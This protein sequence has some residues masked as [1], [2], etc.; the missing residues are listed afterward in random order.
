MKLGAKGNNAGGGGRRVRKGQFSALQ[1]HH[2]LPEKML[3]LLSFFLSEVGKSPKAGLA[4]FPVNHLTNGI[5]APC[6]LLRADMQAVVRMPGSIY[7]QIWSNSLPPSQSGFVEL[8]RKRRRVPLPAKQPRREGREGKGPPLFASQDFCMPTRSFLRG[9]KRRRRRRRRRTPLLPTKFHFCLFSPPA[10]TPQY[11][12]TFIRTLSR[13]AER[14]EDP[15][16]QYP[17][18]PFLCAFRFSTP[19]FFSGKSVPSI[20]LLL[21]CAKRLFRLYG[22]RA[23]RWR[24]FKNHIPSPVLFIFPLAAISLHS[25]LFCEPPLFF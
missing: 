16:P 13:A 17:S 14:G 18:P 20:C 3:L 5:N 8:C 7:S 1:P 22:L 2:R 6:H 11:P 4:V 12:R 15:K 10:N 24:V 21:P 9:R 25:H 19:S 23:G